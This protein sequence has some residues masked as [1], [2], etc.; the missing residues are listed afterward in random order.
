MLKFSPGG[1][2]VGW[3]P[4][5][6]KEETWVRTPSMARMRHGSLVGQNASIYKE[7]IMFTVE[8]VLQWQGISVVDSLVMTDLCKSKSEAR[9][10]IDQ[11]AIKVDDMKVTNHDAVILFSPDRSK[12]VLVELMLP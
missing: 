7:I 2:Y 11:G 6:S 3:N 4:T 9:R 12:H 5:G 8:E 1:E 10:M